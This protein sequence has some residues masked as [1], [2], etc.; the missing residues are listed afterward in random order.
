MKKILNILVYLVIITLV[1]FTFEPVTNRLANLLIHQPNVVIL[2]PNPYH[3]DADFRFIQQTDH[4]VPYSMQD[5]KNI[6]YTVLNHGWDRF[7]F[8]CPREYIHC[9]R[10]IETINNSEVL[11]HIN[12]FVAPFN[13]F[14]TITVFHSAAGEVTIEIDW[15]YS[16]EM[17]NTLNARIDEIIRNTITDEMDIR[18]KILAIHDYIIHQTIYDIHHETSEFSSNTAYGSLIQGRAI[19]SGYTDAMALFLN[20]FNIPNFKVA[21]HDH[22]WNAVYIDGEWLHLDLTWNDPVDENDIYNQSIRHTFFLITTE[23]LKEFE[24]LN[25]D[26][27]PLIY[28]EVAL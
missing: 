9:R 28:Q 12:N 15:L 23:T 19:C 13:G 11:S 21:S 5:L 1:I 14:R 8:Y 4:F 18:D 26:F 6:F 16:Q 27:N 25:H 10:D 7:T 3:R 2:P 22:V 20:R 24:I 17:I